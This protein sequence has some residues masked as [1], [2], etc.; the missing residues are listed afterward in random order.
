M[1]TQLMYVPGQERSQV[2]AQLLKVQQYAEA[3]KM[4]R[5]LDKKK[6]MLF[7]LC[8][9]KDFMPEVSV[10]CDLVEKT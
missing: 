10:A 8:I 1:A 5:N 4:K 6:L 9:S 3:N 2:Y 7:N